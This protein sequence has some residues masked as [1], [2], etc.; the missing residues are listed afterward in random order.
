MVFALER[1]PNRVYGCTN[2]VRRQRSGGRAAKS[3][4]SRR[5]PPMA[6][7]EGR[8]RRRTL[9]PGALLPHGLTQGQMV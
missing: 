8:W 7:A 3:V 6:A 1:S 2:R 4:V 9:N 5:V